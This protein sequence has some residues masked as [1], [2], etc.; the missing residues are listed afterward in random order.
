[1]TNKNRHAFL[2][3]AWTS[4]DT[5][6]F[7]RCLHCLSGFVAQS[8]YCLI[9]VSYTHLDV[10]KRQALMRRSYPYERRSYNR[11]FK[12]WRTIDLIRSGEVVA[13]RLLPTNDVLYIYFYQITLQS[14]SAIRNNSLSKRR[15]NI[16]YE[17]STYTFRVPSMN[18]FFSFIN[19][20][21]AT[22]LSLYTSEIRLCCWR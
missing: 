11:T 8:Q 14:P 9:S 12:R 16:I 10:Y 3:T 6:R 15:N 19:A 7:E 17:S 18:S 21:S 5:W 22:F 4:P 13:G 2:K 20:V 1:M